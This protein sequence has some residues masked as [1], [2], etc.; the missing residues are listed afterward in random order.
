ME[1]KEGFAGVVGFTTPG[2]GVLML[3]C[4]AGSH[5]VKMRCYFGGLLFTSRHGSRRLVHGDDVL[6]EVHLS[7]G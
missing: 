4:G 6:G 5:I 3:R 7:C 1:T 2:I